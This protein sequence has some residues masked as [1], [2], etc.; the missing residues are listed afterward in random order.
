GYTVLFGTNSTYAI[1]PNILQ[2]LSYDN[3]KAFAPVG[4]VLRSPQMLC[5]SPAFPVNTVPELLDHVQKH[6]SNEVNFASAGPGST[7]HMAMELL[8]SI[9]QIR[10]QHVPY[11]GGAPALQALMSGEASV[12]FVD[13]STA[14]PVAKSG[15]LRMLAASTAERSAL[16]PNLPTI[17][18]TVPGF[19]STTDVS[20][21]VPAGTPDPAIQRLS[22]AIK[23]AFK[24]PQVTK[25]LLEAG[26]I[27]VAGTP[28]EFPQYFAEE[29]AKWR[30]LIETQNIKLQ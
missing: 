26:L 11:R 2:S 28:E 12:G 17:A 8:M 14:L 19:Q 3:D 9:A 16:Q 10:M 5:V 1:A 23:T 27:L 18:E 7:S 25:P 21:F 29:R 22:A 30:K 20:C 4:L 15:M 6:P 13:L 24:L